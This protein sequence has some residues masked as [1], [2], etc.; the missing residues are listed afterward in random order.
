M[1]QRCP[2]CNTPIINYDEEKNVCA[3][4][5][6]VL[7]FGYPEFEAYQLEDS[8][9]EEQPHRMDMSEGWVLPEF[10]TAPTR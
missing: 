8:Q 9:S 7:E 3:L 6:D 1:E 2:R 5:R 4:C 10:L